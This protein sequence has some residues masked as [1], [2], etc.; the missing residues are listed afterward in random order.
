MHHSTHLSLCRSEKTLPAGDRHIQ[1]WLGHHTAASTGGWKIPPSSICKLRPVGE[2]GQ[3]PFLALKWAVTQQFKEYLMYQP[4]TMQTDNN[5]LTYVLTMLN[6]DATG[7]RWVSALAG[8]NFR[9][10]YLCSTDNQVANVLSR[11]EIRL[12]DNATNEYLQSLDESS[13]NVKNISDDAENEKAQPLT[14]VEKN[15]MNEIMERAW[16]S[17]I[18][19]AETN[20]PALVAKHEEFE[21]ELNVQVAT[22]IM[23]KHIKHNLMGLDWKSLQQNNPIIQ[24]ILKWKCQNSDKNA[25][26]DKNTNWHTLEEYLV[27]VVNSYD[28][29]AYGDWQKDFT[30]LNDMLFINDTPKGSTDMALLFMVPAS[31][32][33]VALDLYHRDVGHQGRDRTYSL[34][35]ERFWWLKMRTQM[36]MTLQNCEKCKVYEKKDP[37]ASLCTIAAT[38]PM[39]LMHIDLVGMEV[40]VK[41][42]KKPVVQKILVVTDHFSW[43]VQAYKVKDKRTITTTKCLYDNYFRHYSFPQHL[44]SDQGTEFCNAV[45]NEMFIYLNIKKLCTSPYHPQTNGAVKHVHQ[46]LEQMI[47]KLDN[48][49]CRKWPKHLSSVTHTYNSTRSQVTGYSLYFLMM[50]CRPWL[51]IDLLFSTAWTLPGTKG[52]NE[53][54][55]ALYEWLREA[56]KLACISADQ[57][58]AQHKHLYNH[59]A[60]VMELR[61]G[62]KVLVWLDTYQGACQ[63]LKN[64]WGS[65]LH[66]VVGQIGDDIPAYVIENEKGKQKV[67][68]CM[69][70]LLWSSAEEEEGLQMTTAQLAFQVSMLVLEP[71]PIGEERSRVPYSWSINGFSLNLASFQSMLDASEPKTGPPAPV[72]PAETPLKE[73]V[74]QRRKNGKR[75]NSTGDGNAVLVG[76]APP[77]TGTHWVEPSPILPGRGKN[78]NG[79]SYMS[80]APHCPPLQEPYICWG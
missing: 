51:P 5:P 23:E 6:L 38:E 70:L 58:A 19:H 2:R 63:K 1:I 43:F 20:N 15:A 66:M 22:M 27:M 17:H 24:H 72:V 32:C 77:W 41:T 42:K 69:W 61:H 44:L 29:K 8:F 18:P 71:L 64:R 35:Q 46:T 37:K 28:T 25:K 79:I 33:Q 45:L 53:Y 67:L 55:K 50:G 47:A 16:F 74:G 39:D 7:H 14:K 76:D 52:V 65:M 10:E 21:K 62:D 54:V 56:I 75:D 31:K 48:K 57:E 3:L 40:T 4:F 60:G 11:M 73:G 26:K 36:M 34:L 9:L 13:Y 49:Q 12:D 30:L 78:W 59:R 68:H 80:F